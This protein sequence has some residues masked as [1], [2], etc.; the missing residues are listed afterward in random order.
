LTN[1]AGLL[2]GIA[3]LC[4]AKKKVVSTEKSSILTD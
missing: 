1:E 2:A 4:K 3:I